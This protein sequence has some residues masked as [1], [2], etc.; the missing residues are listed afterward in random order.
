MGKNCVDI[1]LLHI[2]LILLSTKRLVKTIK[3]CFKL[4]CHG[5]NRIHNPEGMHTD[6]I[7]LRVSASLMTDIVEIQLVFVGMHIFSLWI[8]YMLLFWRRRATSS[9]S[10]LKTFRLQ[11]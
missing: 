2:S 11:I 8:C 10:K 5:T 7:S 1:K 9:T 4:S 6:E 3:S